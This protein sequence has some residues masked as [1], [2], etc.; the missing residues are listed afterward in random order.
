MKKG[1]NSETSENF[2]K[3]KNAFL[4]NNMQTLW[5]K[6]QRASS[7]GVGSSDSAYIHTHYI[8]SDSIKTEA[9]SFYYYIFTS[10][11]GVSLFYLEV[12]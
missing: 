7:K 9:P 8:H 6:F 10:M 3:V 11:H 12:K 1:D 2:K 5:F 4:D